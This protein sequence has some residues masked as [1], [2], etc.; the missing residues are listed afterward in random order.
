MAAVV[1]GDTLEINVDARELRVLLTDEEI[2]KRLANWTA[3]SPR[4]EHGVF[5]KYA[6]TVRSASE[7]A[8]TT[9]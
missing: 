4:Y 1:D 5:A 9:P 6:A 2:E 7:G 8:I 3:P